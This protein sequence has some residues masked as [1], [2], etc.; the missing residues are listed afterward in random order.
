[1]WELDY[2]ESWVPKNW[3]FWTVALEKTLESPLDCKEIQPVHPKGNQ[4][5]IFTGRTDAEAETPILL[6]PW[7]QEPTHWK[8]P[9][10]WETLKAG[11]ECDN[12][13]QAGWMASSTQW[14]WV[15]AFVF[16]S[17]S[18]SNSLWHH[19]RSTPGFL[20]HHQLLEPTQTH[21]HHIGDAIQPSHPLLSPSPPTFNLPQHQGLFQWFGSLH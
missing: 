7:C 3:C 10:C 9:W 1:M 20:V 6:A 16:Q 18:V 13:G 21:G 4:S 11:R 14:T 5:W 19:G 2:K 8:R 17:L 12:R 15:W